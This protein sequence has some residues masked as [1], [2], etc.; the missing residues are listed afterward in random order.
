MIGRVK[1]LTVVKKRRGAKGAV[2][3]LGGRQHAQ[4]EMLATPQADFLSNFTKPVSSSMGVYSTEDHNS[5]ASTIGHYLYPLSAKYTQA[6][7]TQE[8][9]AK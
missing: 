2:E 4:T 6:D 5:T 1:A 3:K 7:R 8:L 9:E